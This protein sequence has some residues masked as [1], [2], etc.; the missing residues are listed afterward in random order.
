MLSL[1][2]LALAL[3]VPFV[4]AGGIIDNTA[5]AAAVNVSPFPCLLFAPCRDM[6]QHRHRPCT[7]RSLLLDD[8]LHMS[9]HLLLLFLSIGQ[10]FLSPYKGSL[11]SR[12]LR[13][14]PR[15]RCCFLILHA[16]PRQEHTH[17]PI[18]PRS[19]TDTLAF[20]SLRPMPRSAT[21]TTMSRTSPM[22]NFSSS[23]A[24]T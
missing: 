23:S 18:T 17:T 22:A 13:S 10:P 15:A 1:L 5:I 24:R 3:A 9:W 2:S 12:L 16:R 11:L 14:A 19:N 4:K 21:A 6:A 8:E 7:T 20:S